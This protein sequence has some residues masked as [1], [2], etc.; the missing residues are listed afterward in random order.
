MNFHFE[1]DKNLEAEIN[2]TTI[3]LRDQTEKLFKR[4]KNTQIG[5][6][7]CLTDDFMARDNKQN[8]EKHFKLIEE[9]CKLDRG[10]ESV[11][12]CNKDILNR[13]VKKDLKIK[14]EDQLKR[15]V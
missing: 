1:E 12:F 11:I 3:R 10:L 5:F 13:N 8:L 4:I 2:Q 6:N 7:E 9:T 15:Y 14:S